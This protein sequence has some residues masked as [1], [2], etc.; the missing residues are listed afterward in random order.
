AL[1]AELDGDVYLNLQADEPLIAPEVIDAVAR[2]FDDPSVQMATAVTPLTRPEDWED[3]NAVKTV[4]DR[5]SDCLYFSR[6][7]IPY[8]RDNRGRLPESSVYKHLGIY[9]YRR[10]FLQ[11][12]AAWPPTPLEKIERLEQ[13][14]ALEHGVRLRAVVTPFDSPSVDTPEDLARVAAI[15]KSQKN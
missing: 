4:L 9:G 8:D 6:A 14:R 5:N 11:E 3:T 13:L 10:K 15:L 2:S 12:F 1:A 7:A